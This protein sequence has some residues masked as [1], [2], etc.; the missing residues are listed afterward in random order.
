MNH[1]NAAG[2]HVPANFPVF[3][4]IASRINFPIDIDQALPNQSLDPIR[5]LPAT[6]WREAKDAPDD[7]GQ[8]HAG[9]TARQAS[10]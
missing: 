4:L 8:V 7:G 6:H 9:H 3:T 10:T 5:E 1:G 2:L